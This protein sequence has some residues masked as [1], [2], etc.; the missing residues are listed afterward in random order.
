MRGRNLW[1]VSRITCQIPEIFSQFVINFSSIMVN[2]NQVYVNMYG[3]KI[4][5]FMY[6]VLVNGA[7]S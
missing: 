4:S 6:N 2:F 3:K 5:Y 1:I 7:S